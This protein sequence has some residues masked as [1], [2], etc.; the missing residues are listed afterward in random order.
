ML[1][2]IGNVSD[3][4]WSSILPEPKSYPLNLAE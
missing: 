4:F 2:S 1:L 3:P